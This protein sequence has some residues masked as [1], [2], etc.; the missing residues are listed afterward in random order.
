MSA[1]EIRYPGEPAAS[2]A[3]DRIFAA[4]PVYVDGLFAE[5]VGLDL[6]TSTEELVDSLREQWG[7][8]QTLTPAQLRTLETIVRRGR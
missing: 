7:T 2:S 5:I 8:R 6:H 1:D 4:D 3:R